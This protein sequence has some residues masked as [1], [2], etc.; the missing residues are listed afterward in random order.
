MSFTE[1]F[2]VTVK[3]KKPKAQLPNPKTQKIMNK[4]RIKEFF[5]FGEV[6]Q[7]FIRVFK[8]HDPKHPTNFNLRMMHGINRISIIMF[9]FCLIVI[10]LKFVLRSL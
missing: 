9:L 3:L 2:Q 7:Y 6:F 8:K 5:Q 4:Q 1:L 10:I